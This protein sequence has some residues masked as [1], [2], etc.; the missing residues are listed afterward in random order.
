MCAPQFRTYIKIKKKA[1]IYKTLFMV[2]CIC[3]TH[4]TATYYIY[5]PTSKDCYIFDCCCYLRFIFIYISHLMCAKD[6]LSLNVILLKYTYIHS[7]FILPFCFFT[8]SFFFYFFF[9]YKFW[10]EK[11]LL[12]H[13]LTDDVKVNVSNWSFY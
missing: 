11:Y 9:E 4:S 10:R 7:H 13:S 1:N 3:I 12:S 6:V 8:K 5:V 2:Y